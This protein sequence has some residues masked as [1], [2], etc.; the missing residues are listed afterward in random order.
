MFQRMGG[1]V[2]EMP[3]SAQAAWCWYKH[4]EEELQGFLTD[5]LFGDAF[6]M[7]PT[8]TGKGHCL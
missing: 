3:G 5:T 2:L 4:V 7:A 6:W 8:G 1:L